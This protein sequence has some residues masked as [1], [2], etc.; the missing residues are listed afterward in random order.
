MNFRPYGKYLPRETCKEFMK[1]LP[2][3]AKAAIR[4]VKV[5]PMSAPTF[6]EYARSIST[7]PIPHKGVNVDSVIEDD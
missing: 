6:I 1:P 4:L 2:V 7:T 3:E 5:V